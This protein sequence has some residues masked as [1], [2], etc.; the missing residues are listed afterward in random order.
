MP[1][2]HQ[3]VAGFSNG[4]AISNEARVLQ[5]LFRS[6]GHDSEIYCEQKRI[7]PELRA[8]ARDAAR[9]RETMKPDDIAILH[10]SIG[11]IVNDLFAAIPCRR[12]IIYH[13]ITPPEFFRGL[14]EEITHHL[15]RGLEQV[16]ALAGKAEVV[17]AVSRFNAHELEAAGHRDVKIL[18]LF[19]DR[20]HWKVAPSRRVI[21][22]FGGDKTNILFVGRGAPNKRIEDLLFAFYY[23]Q[24]YVEPDSR[25]IHVGS[26]AG[27]DR[28]HALLR[29][30]AVELKL[31]D[32]IFPG[33]VRQDELNGYYKIAHV[34]LC[35]SEHE[36]F[37]IPL[38]EAM[39]H[40]VPV[41]AYAA[42]AVPETLDGAGMLF[43]EKQFDLIA[44]AMGRL[45]G[46][47]ALRRGVL[48]RQDERLARY[49]STDL[50]ADL[51]RNLAP[52]L[53]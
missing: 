8:S 23:F 40:R 14:Q 45:A 44:E 37:C 48:A 27:L 32:V 5:K 34:F 47:A 52:L 4:D 18:P 11:S 15:Q 49:A 29:A 7:L 36:G 19:L 43:R 1:A 31:N 42:G 50:A 17:M 12:A 25:L 22:L 26:Y 33:S 38:L 35:M 2:I 39:A 20:E 16:R 46:D 21:G 10:L 30:K 51:R 6:W 53:S 13:N 3:F 28:Y 41:L 24:R 9:A